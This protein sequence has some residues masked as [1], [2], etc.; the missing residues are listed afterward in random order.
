MQGEREKDG[1]SVAQFRCVELFQKPNRLVMLAEISQRARQL[2]CDSVRVLSVQA[3]LQR[4]PIRLDG[5]LFET[6]RVMNSAPLGQRERVTGWSLVEQGAHSGKHHLS[7]TLIKRR[8]KCIDATLHPS[9]WSRGSPPSRFQR[10]V[11]PP[12]ETIGVHGEDVSVGTER[13]ADVEVRH[14]LTELFRCRHISGRIDIQ[15]VDGRPPVADDPDPGPP[16]RVVHDTEPVAAGP[17]IA[18]D[19]AR[20]FRRAAVTELPEAREE[21]PRAPLLGPVSLQRSNQF[22]MTRAQHANTIPST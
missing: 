10:D 17:G 19:Y 21:R 16:G 12:P 5:A 18:H 15:A 11:P 4:R 1:G 9:M 2:K 3:G 6:E 13:L 7:I 22:R 20:R 8:P 14:F